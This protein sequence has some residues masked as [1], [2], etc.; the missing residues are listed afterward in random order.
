MKRHLLALVLLVGCG[1]AHADERVELSETDLPGAS[2][3]ARG[4]WESVPLSGTAWNS[5]PGRATL[6]FPHQLGRVPRI[7]QVFLAFDESG[8]GAGLAAGDLARVMA[9][10]DQAIEIKNDTD[11][12]YFVR[13]VV[14]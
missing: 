14:Q 5:Y 1:N 2:L 4:V 13:V 11:G 9:A 10:T 3:D 12:D 6:V 7:V 8:R